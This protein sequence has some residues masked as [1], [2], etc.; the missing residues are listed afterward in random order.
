MFFCNIYHP[1]ASIEA[2]LY[3]IPSENFTPHFSGTAVKL[4]GHQSHFGRSFIINAMCSVTQMLV[5]LESGDL[6]LIPGGTINFSAESID[7]DG[8]TNHNL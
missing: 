6:D 4:V 1:V 5:W 7:N 3:L 8:V 2:I